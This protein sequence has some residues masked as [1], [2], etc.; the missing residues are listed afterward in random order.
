MKKL[1]FKWFPK[2][3]IVKNILNLD[4]VEVIAH[5]YR[6][7]NVN[8]ETNNTFEGLGITEERSFELYKKMI[9]FIKDEKVS[10]KIQLLIKMEPDIKHINEFYVTT[11]LMEKLLAKMSGTGDPFLDFLLK[12]KNEKGE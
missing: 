3:F 1:L 4:Q 11:L 6:L 7:A 2:F 12:L 5:P 10:C 9:H 8:P